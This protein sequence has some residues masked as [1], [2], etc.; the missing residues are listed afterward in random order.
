MICKLLHNEDDITLTV[1]LCIIEMLLYHGGKY[2]Y[3]YNDQ[4]NAFYFGI[5]SKN[6]KCLTRFISNLIMF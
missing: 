4:H 3:V 5:C 2:H 6:E 1:Y